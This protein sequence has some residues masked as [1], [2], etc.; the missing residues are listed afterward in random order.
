MAPTFLFNYAGVLYRLG[1]YDEAQRVFQ[2]TIRTAR[3]RQMSRIEVDAMMQ[4]ADVYTERGNFRAAEEQLDLVRPHLN[5]PYFNPLKRALLAYSRGLQALGRGEPVKARA[6]LAESTALFESAKAR[7]AQ[8]VHALIGLARAEAALGNGEAAEA[9]VRRAVALAESMVE[10]GSPSYLVGCAKAA[11]GE[12]QL[13]RGQPEAA[14][15]SLTGALTHLQP[16][17]GT[18][19]PATSAARRRLTESDGGAL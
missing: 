9:A 8:N 15:T 1:Q 13:A 4:L 14:R 17:L 19:H 12:I 6:E 5:R 18:D 2:E 10:R 7:L 3:D 16:T 11:L